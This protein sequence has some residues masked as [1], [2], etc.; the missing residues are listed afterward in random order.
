MSLIAGEEVAGIDFLGDIGE[1]SIVAVGEDG[2][3]ETFELRE[4]VDQFASEEC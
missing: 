1:D 2:T 4:V 3:A